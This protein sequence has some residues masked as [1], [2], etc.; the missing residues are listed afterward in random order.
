MH[1]T[2]WTVIEA[3]GAMATIVIMILIGRDGIQ[4]PLLYHHAVVKVHNE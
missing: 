4:G 3:A 1:T 2:C